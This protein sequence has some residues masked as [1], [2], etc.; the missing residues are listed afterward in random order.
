MDE[1]QHT[2]LNQNTFYHEEQLRESW[3]QAPD[4]DGIIRQNSE[5]ISIYN[6]YLLRKRNKFKR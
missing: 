3:H 2:Q 4:N 1:A 5:W 6:T